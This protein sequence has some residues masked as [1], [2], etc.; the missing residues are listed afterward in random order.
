MS[1]PETDQTKVEENVTFLS[2][3]QEEITCTAAGERCNDSAIVAM[4]SAAR[5]PNETDKPDQREEREA[6]H[7][8]SWEGS[9]VQ[10]QDEVDACHFQKRNEKR[11]S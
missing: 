4:C 9:L 10:P 3:D 2:P 11:S 7:K 5:H 6:F 1:D 8:G